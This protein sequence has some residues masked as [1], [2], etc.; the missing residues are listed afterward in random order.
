MACSSCGAAASAGGVLRPRCERRL[1]DGLLWSHSDRPEEKRAREQAQTSIFYPRT[2]LEIGSPI[3]RL[4]LL[5]IIPTFP[6]QTFNL[7][8]LSRCSQTVV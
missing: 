8:F 2:Y 1:S 4:L 5:S 7:P 3:R 6:K